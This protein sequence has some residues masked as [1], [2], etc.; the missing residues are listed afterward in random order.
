[1]W[2]WNDRNRFCWC[3]SWKKLKKCHLSIKQEKKYEKWQLDEMMRDSYSVKKCL[4]PQE[5][6]SECSWIIIKA[7]TISKIN[8]LKLIA[9]DGHVYSHKLSMKELDRTWGK[10]NF[11]LVGI[12]NA[13]TFPW[14]CSYHDKIIFSPLEDQEFTWSIEQLLLLAYRWLV[15]EI[16]NKQANLLFLN[17][18]LD[19]WLDIKT[20][21]WFQEFKEL[22]MTW[23]KL[24]ISDLQRILRFYSTSLVNVSYS[25][26]EY[27]YCIMY[28]DTCPPVMVSSWFCPCYDFKGNKLQDLADTSAECDEVALNAISIGENKWAFIFFARNTETA[29]SFLRSFLE[30]PDVYKVTTFLRFIFL[31]SENIYISPDRW[32]WLPSKVREFFLEDINT[33]ITCYELPKNEISGPIKWFD[34]TLL[35]ISTNIVITY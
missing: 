16:Y 23:T 8:N 7:H 31:N 21:K 24:A 26:N 17:N 18:K 25:E 35:S 19:V 12:N 28:I 30:I 11:K 9:R 29:R 4:A 13:S 22:R 27:I 2:K 1:M 15:K 32:D 14:F 34:V 10:I 3:G 20:K 5:M 6:Q 33:N